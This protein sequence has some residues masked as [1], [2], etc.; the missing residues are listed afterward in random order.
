M[1][2]AVFHWKRAKNFLLFA[3]KH[4]VKQVESLVFHPLT[5]QP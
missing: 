1:S 2:F 4:L 3:Q 5:F